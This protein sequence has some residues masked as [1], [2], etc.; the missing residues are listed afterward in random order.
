M[1]ERVS[2]R[3]RSFLAA[4]GRGED[5]P[6][7][8]EEPN[9]K[10]GLFDDFQKIEPRSVFMLAA[11]GRKG[12]GKQPSVQV[13]KKSS[14][15]PLNSDVTAEELYKLRQNQKMKYIFVIFHTPWCKPCKVIK[16]KEYQ[17]KIANFNRDHPDMGLVPMDLEDE[18]NKFIA[19]AVGNVA[20]PSVMY[21]QNSD[22]QYYIE[23][24]STPAREECSHLVDELNKDNFEETRR[25]PEAIS[26]EK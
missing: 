23:I 5:L 12:I 2:Y 6:S 8:E 26:P 11:N 24:L 15:T 7:L 1:L 18:R 13:A 17:K 21:L 4:D 14:P 10:E 25:L 9:S 22:G 3:I 19:K 16:T 20:F